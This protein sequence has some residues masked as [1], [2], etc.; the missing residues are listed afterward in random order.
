MSMNP[1]WPFAFL[2]KLPSSGGPPKREVAIPMF[3]SISPWLANS[4]CRT[5][6]HCSAT[7]NG[8]AWSRQKK[9][10]A[11]PN[12]KSE[13]QE[14]AYDVADVGTLDDEST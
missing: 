11:W 13:K 1:T 10:L 4:S 7:L 6:V 2:I 3:T 9:K 14:E 8:R 5:S 12:F